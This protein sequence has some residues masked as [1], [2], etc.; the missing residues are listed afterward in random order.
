MPGPQTH[1]LESKADIVFYGGA[2]GGGKTDLLLGAALDHKRTIIFRREF[3]QLS[4]IV[5]RS[6]EVFGDFAKYNGKG[7]WRWNNEPRKV[8]F[9]SCQHIGDENKYQGQPHDL[10]CFDE[11][12]HFAEIQFRTIIGW[13]RT[14]DPKQRVRVLAAGN[15]PLQPEEEWVVQFFAPWLDPTHAN[16]AAPAELRWYAMVKGIDTEVDDN[17]PFVIIN[18]EITYNFEPSEFKPI[19][20][21]KPLSRTFIPASVENNP[22]YMA[23][24]YVNQLA[25]LPEP[26]RSK[27]LYG[28]FNAGKDD[29]PWQV[30]PSAWVLAAQE[31]WKQR[32]ATVGKP[33]TRMTAMGIDV[34]RGGKDKT[35]LSPWYDNFMDEQ[36]LHAGSTTPDGPA[37]A[38]LCINCRDIKRG[39]TNTRLNI[40]IIG[41]GTSPYDCL[42]SMHGQ[43]TYAMNGSEG[44]DARDKAGL[45]GFVN[46]RAQWWWQ[47]REALDPSSGQDICLP[48][49]RTLYVDLC[50]PRWKPTARGIQ[51]EAKEDI[52]KR[53]KRSPDE[54]DSCVYGHAQKYYD[55]WGLVEHMRRQVEE[56]KKQGG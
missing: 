29:N 39:D 52:I 40:D 6:R 37:V 10:I 25:A 1:A 32:V 44:T 28:N 26:L 36:E 35:I 5:D 41:V 22:Y 49:S 20:I 2:A 42:V 48:P 56:Q 47:F 45:L 30:I 24:G 53:I 12:P 4:A 19:E 18:G 3:T 34:A 55:N 14:A 7:Y 11:L 54:G 31:R 51:I 43:Q 23:S 38:G 9:G 50:T 46:S 17:R 21:I 16:P 27:L 8:E 33:T 13:L 15:P